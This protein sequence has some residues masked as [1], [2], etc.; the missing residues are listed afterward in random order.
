[1]DESESTFTSIQLPDRFLTSFQHCFLCCHLCAVTK[2]LE[3]SYW[4]LFHIFKR[5]SIPC[6]THDPHNSG[7]LKI[8]ICY[9]LLMM[10]V[11]MVDVMYFKWLLLEATRRHA[12]AYG[13]VR[14]G[15]AHET[16]FSN[17]CETSRYI[18]TTI[19]DTPYA[20]YNTRQL[21]DICSLCHTCSIH[22]KCYFYTY[23]MH[24]ICSPARWFM[25][26]QLL[27]VFLNKSMKWQ[28]V[29]IP[30]LFTL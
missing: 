2:T 30:A 28:D 22:N 14:T 26:H 4:F 1:M 20:P 25:Y 3:H 5:Q 11:M 10:I 17:V 27:P 8:W 12:G 29:N 13:T 6:Q 19:H 21:W 9:R 18:G 15:K 16:K 24:H 23:T 7:H